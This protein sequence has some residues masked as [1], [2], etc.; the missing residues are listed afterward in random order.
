MTL[1]D[2]VEVRFPGITQV[3]INDGATF[4]TRFAWNISAEGQ[5][6]VT[7]TPPPL[8]TLFQRLRTRVLVSEEGRPPR[9]LDYA[10]RGSLDNWLRAGA[11]R[12][13]LNA[14]EAWWRGE[15]AIWII[16]EANQQAT[17]IRHEARDDAAIHC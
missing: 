17:E 16:S 15:L 5:Y 13:A 2:P 8:E 11:L 7:V 12:L 10:G 3:Q 14:L 4:K 6:D 9:I 1:E